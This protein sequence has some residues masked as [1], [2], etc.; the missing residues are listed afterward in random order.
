MRSQFKREFTS[1]GPFRRFYFIQKAIAFDGRDLTPSGTIETNPNIAFCQQALSNS[2]FE[3]SE[4]SVY[5]NPTNGQFRLAFDTDAQPL[6]VRVTSADGKD[7]FRDERPSFDGIY[8]ETIDLSDQPAGMYFVEIRQ[9][10]RAV[11]KQIIIQ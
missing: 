1:E 2:E 6:S 7:L 5:P 9:R 8:D 10:D 4:I 11:T 3:L